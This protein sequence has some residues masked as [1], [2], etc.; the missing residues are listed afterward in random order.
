MKQRILA[1]GPLFGQGFEKAP[2]LDNVD[3]AAI[4]VVKTA[5]PKRMK[6]YL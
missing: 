1:G 4:A 5:C 2:G 3:S 6:K